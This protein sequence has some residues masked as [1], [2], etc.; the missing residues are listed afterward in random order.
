VLLAKTLRSTTFRLA[1]ISIGVFGAV[2]IALFGY[3]YWS[4]TSFV[5]S[6]SDSAIE[7]EWSTLRNVYDRSGREGLIQ[8]IE[9]RSTAAPLEGSVYLLA[10][11]SFAP[12]T[13]N[14][15]NWPPVKRAG[16]WS[17]FK[18][19]T[20]NSRPGTD[21]RLFRA[22]WDTLPDGFH[23]LLGKDISDLGRFAT[24]IYAALAFALLIIFLLAA[25]ASE[26]YATYR[27]QN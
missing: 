27:G 16:E 10:D 18:S 19:G 2:V 23:L 21:Q 14:L 8:A 13:G 15:K 17:E 26:C 7:A 24:E 6:R 3:V 4:T 22:K 11:E 20:L 9:R 1:L 5:L 25:V 12:V